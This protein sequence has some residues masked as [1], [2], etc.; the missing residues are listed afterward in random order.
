MGEAEGRPSRRSLVVLVALV[1]AVSGGSSWWAAR[2]KQDIGR[3]VAD[4][5][6]PGDIRMLASTTC[7]SCFVAR[8]WFREHRVPF[9]ECYIDRDEACAREFAATRLPGTPVLLVRG[10]PQLG[11]SPERLRDSL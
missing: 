2:L 6:R 5:A 11:F 9:S 7:A 4:K 1:L 3:E 8:Q 10:V